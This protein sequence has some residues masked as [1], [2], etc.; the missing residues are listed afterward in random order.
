MQTDWQLKSATE[1]TEH[2]WLNW[3]RLVDSEHNGNLIYHRIFVA[4]LLQY[5][6]TDY[7]LAICKIDNVV[8]QMCFLQRHRLGIWHLV[9]PSQATSAL[10]VGKIDTDWHKLFA[11]LPGLVWRLDL[12]SLDSQDHQLLINS[13][14]PKQL[15]TKSLDITI[16]LQNSFADYLERRPKNLRKNIGRYL[17]RLTQDSYQ[18]ELTLIQSP[19][20]IAEAVNRYAKLESAGWKGQQGT[21]LDQDNT[22]TL[23]YRTVLTSLAEQGKVLI[24]ELHADHHLIASRL[25]MYDAERFI[26]LKTTYD[27]SQKQYAPGRLLLHK[28]LE[29]LFSAHLSKTIDFYT[30]ST[31]EQ[32]D[33][34][35]HARLFYNCSVFRN[36]VFGRG[37][38]L[39]HA[40]LASARVLLKR[41]ER[42]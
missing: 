1:I 9:H 32:I 33:W 11:L 37:H 13:K 23:F 19:E 12:Y 15:D 20:H 3:Q 25:C 41:T 2:D 14:H 35:T 42:P 26:I 40:L 6:A 24:A 8:R 38:H 30:N 39:S 17:R 29:H 4:G 27:E 31:A 18:L 28:L 7:Y 16:D 22:Q 34:S 21:A 10:I 36:K 5:F